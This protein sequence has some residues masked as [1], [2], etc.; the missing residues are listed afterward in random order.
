MRL[1]TDVLGWDTTD[2]A[3]PT[4]TQAIL[5]IVTLTIS[6][7][8]VRIVYRLFFHPLSKF[9]GPKI[10][11][12]SH[13]PE[14]YYDLLHGQG[15]QFPA[16]IREWHEIYGPIVRINPD[17][18]HVKDSQWYDTCYSASR[19]SWKL[20]PVLKSVGMGKSTVAAEAPGRW[21]VKRR[22][23]EPF[24]SRRNIAAF[25][26]KM[27]EN[28]ARV[29]DRVKA[30]YVGT[31]RVLTIDHM[32]ECFASD[33]IMDYAFDEHNDF[34]SSPNFQSSIN[35]GMNALT[36]NSNIL[37]HFPFI[38]QLIDGLPASWVGWIDP[39]VAPV[40]KVRDDLSKKITNIC[41]HPDKK[42]GSATIFTSLIHGNVLPKEEMTH[43]A[44]HQEAMSVIGAGVE[45]VNRSLNL[46]CFH[47]IDN[48]RVR[49]RLLAELNEA[50]PDPDQMPSWDVLVKLPYL[51]GYVEECFRLTYGVSQRRARSFRDMP[52]TF[53][54]WEIP[55]G[56][57]VGMDNYDVSHDEAIFP[58]SFSFM[59]ERWLNDPK[60]PDG[61]PL[62]RYMVTFGKGLRN[63]AGMHM[64]YAEMFI[65]L[66]H[67]ARSG[68]G[69]RAVL[70]EGTSVRDVEMARDT[71]V[72]R[73]YKGSRGVR[74]RFNGE[75]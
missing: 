23:M 27:Q 38:A 2:M 12:A 20:L 50:I 54:T 19:P 6:S 51:S 49:E 32:W 1:L 41:A 71:L 3:S 24:F 40:L 4:V 34:I 46:G 16:K 69:S 21:A 28:M 17:E 22:A 48:S 65:G 66:A 36:E 68:I 58:D 52:V 37:K 63:C 31:D 9:P 10:A 39:S 43:V 7:W 72:A 14:F 62:S 74:V 30:E 26:P 75:V 25:G 59:P 35:A 15:G 64:A 55:P 13:W 70:A 45:T 56:A 47:F 8:I 61:R 42:Q 73:P 67:F 29:I 57:W 33:N 11:A 53:R 60:A 5:A 18:L 44:L